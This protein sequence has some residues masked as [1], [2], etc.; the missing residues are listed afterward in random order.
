MVKIEFLEV[1]IQ[2]C[3]LIAHPDRK[4]LT[5]S[6]FQLNKYLIY[7]YISVLMIYDIDA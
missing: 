6:V 7:L 5:C 1:K 2:N 3:A 4:G